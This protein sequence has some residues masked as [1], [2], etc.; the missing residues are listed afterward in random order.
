MGTN[1]RPGQRTGGYV[2]GDTVKGE[3]GRSGSTWGND[4]HGYGGEGAGRGASGLPAAPRAL[5]PE[6]TPGSRPA[7]R[8]T[9]PGQTPR[10]ATLAA[11]RRCPAD[12]GRGARPRPRPAAGGARPRGGPATHPRGAARQPVTSRSPRTQLAARPGALRTR[13]DSSSKSGSPGKFPFFPP[14]PPLPSPPRPQS[15]PGRLRRRL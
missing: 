9:S 14:S 6:L 2:H 5:L 15:G 4:T 12:G 3:E 10:R 13:G 8:R 7:H 1:L 11:P